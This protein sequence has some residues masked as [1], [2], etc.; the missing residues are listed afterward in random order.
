M[1]EQKVME[2]GF[3]RYLVVDLKRGAMIVYASS[4]IDVL[5]EL[6]ESDV[7]EDDVISMTKL[8]LAEEE[9]EEEND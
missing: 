8:D 4:F 2:K 9:E 5:A 6:K 1:E 3:E 7:D